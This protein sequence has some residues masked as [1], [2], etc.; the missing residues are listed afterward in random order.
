MHVDWF[1]TDERALRAL[2]GL[3]E[4]KGQPRVIM[5]KDR[6]TQHSQD[7]HKPITYVLGACL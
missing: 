7:M 6:T 5:L 2:A 4:M 3:R 1:L